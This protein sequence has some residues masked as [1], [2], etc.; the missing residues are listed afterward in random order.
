MQSFLYKKK[1][2]F[3]SLPEDCSYNLI[4]K[5][6]MR[7][8]GRDCDLRRMVTT[9]DSDHHNKPHY[10]IDPG[11]LFDVCSILLSVDK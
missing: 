5:Q 8:E 7:E 9:C 3:T 10:A 1:I 11:Q 6:H 2:K 4:R